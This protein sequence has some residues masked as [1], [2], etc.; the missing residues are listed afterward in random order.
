MSDTIT[1][2]QPPSG[3]MAAQPATATVRGRHDSLVSLDDAAKSSEHLPT[4]EPGMPWPGILTVSL[5]MFTNAYLFSFIFPYMSPLVTHLMPTSPPTAPT[6]GTLTG[7]LTSA[8]MLGGLVSAYPWGAVSDRIGRRPA[9]LLGMWMTPLA[10]VAFG[11][12]GTYAQVVVW[13]A[14]L[15]VTSG[16]VSVC[17]AQMGELCKGAR[18]RARGFG[19]LVGMW[20]AGMVVG[21]AVGGGL[22]GKGWQE[23]P[24]ALVGVVGAGITLVC[25]L[26]ILL[27]LPETRNSPTSSKLPLVIRQPL[28]GSSTPT[29]SS[30]YS[31]TPTSDHDQDSDPPTPLRTLLSTRPILASL[32]MYTCV[33]ALEIAYLVSTALWSQLPTGTLRLTSAQ[34]GLITSTA[35]IATLVYQLFVYPLISTH[36]HP[37]SPLSAFR[38]AI[39]IACAVYLVTPWVASKWA[40]GLLLSVAGMAMATGF[41]SVFV[42]MANVT[43]RDMDKGAVD[44]VGQ[45]MASAARI[46]VPVLS[47]ALFSTSVA[48]E[49]GGNSAGG[50]GTGLVFYV[51]AVVGVGLICGSFAVTRDEANAN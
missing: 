24:F 20:K 5:V 32:L 6:H 14:V 12:A 33:A 8:M 45:G 15:G 51:T 44:G 28:L 29:S 19:V 50:V 41:T 21:P 38:T 35:G 26:A 40:L 1:T 37:L 7:W 22:A 34:L 43:K 27:W 31:L 3:A 46:V 49:Q 4:V 9:M 42:I 36:L 25:S 11:F 13:R 17:R 2:E 39:L 16:V 30:A 18:A 48:M 10:V 47:G 23:R